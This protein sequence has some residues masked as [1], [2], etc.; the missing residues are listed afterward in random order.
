MDSLQHTSISCYETIAVLNEEHN[1]YIVQH[2]KSK[3]I[4]VKKFLTIYNSMIYEHLQKASIPGIPKIIELYEE[5]NTLILIEEYISGEMLEDKINSKTLT[6]DNVNKYV[7]DLCTIVSKLHTLTPP[8]IHRD[9]KPENIIITSADNV[10]LLDFNAAKHYTDAK[11]AD[12]VLL[13]TQ[14]YAAPEQYGFGSSSEQTDIYAIGILLKELVEALPTPTKEF[15]RI[16]K[17]CTNINPKDRYQKTSKIQSQLSYN[18]PDSVS[19]DLTPPG[20]RS[21]NRV[22]AIFATMVY[23]FIFYFNLTLPMDKENTAAYNWL[24][25][26]TPLLIMLSIIF[27]HTNYL[28][29][30]RHM[31]LCKNK[32]QYVRYLGIVI[33]DIII[34]TAIFVITA[35]IS[36]YLS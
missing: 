36:V 1:V 21:E 20:F 17:K 35:I 4:F 6:H 32:N 10:F 26:I 29:I 25:R 22:K 19:S 13:G 30:Q 7:Y 23:I 18:P 34:S 3:K 14:G 31:P 24:A 27:V 2:I 8:I 5:N 9:I 33:L 28:N 12:T 15:D 16:I 11:S